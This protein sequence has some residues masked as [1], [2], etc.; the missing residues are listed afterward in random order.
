MRNL[1][2]FLWNN[3]FF[4]V[5]LILMILSLGLLSGSYSYHKSLRF[6]LISNFSG[7]V[8]G[9]VSGIYDYFSLKMENDKLVAENNL[10]RNQIST[11]FLTTDTN[12]VYRDTLFQYISAKV[13]SNSTSMQS[14]VIIVNKGRIHG[15]EQEMGVMSNEGLV[16]IVTSVSNHYS[17]IM[18]ALHQNANFSAKIKQSGQLVNVSWPGYD[19]TKGKVSDIPSHIQ[20]IKGDTIISSGNSIIF[21]E[22]ILIG[23]VDSHEQNTNKDFSSATI[24]FSVDFNKLHH[25]YLIKNL[26]KTEIDSLLIQNN[27]E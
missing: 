19:F 8:L 2:I 6:S 4:T 18:S 10:L 3:R 9:T 26:M 23:I 12:I 21:P 25:V 24:N 5:F 13:V 14:N 20:L 16:G 15:V 17:S 27:N 1:F 22:G 11:S 7:G